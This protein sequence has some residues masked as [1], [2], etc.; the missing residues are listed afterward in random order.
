MLFDGE[1]SGTAFNVQGSWYARLEGAGGVLLPLAGA[2]P[3]MASLADNHAYSFK[4]RTIEDH[5]GAP[6]QFH[7][8]QARAIGGGSRA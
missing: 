7:V 1:V 2:A 8:I 5:R 4:E 3:T 6:W